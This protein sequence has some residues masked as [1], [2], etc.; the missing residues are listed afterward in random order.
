MAILGL[1]L[2]TCGGGPPPPVEPML[3]EDLC[4]FC[5]MTI[6]DRRLAAEIV[7]RG[8]VDYF[9][10]IGCMLDWIDLH[11]LAPGSMAYVF[12]FRAGEPL[13]AASAFYVRSTLVPTPMGHGLVA[14]AGEAEAS[15]A[16]AELGGTVASWAQLQADHLG[17]S[18]QPEPSDQGE[19]REPD[20]Q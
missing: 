2:L 14:F 13:P 5:R 9:D 18:R 12:D 17:P 19:R 16:A 3:D 6:S 15:A 10:D 11:G 4:S 7:R 1:I 8:G 20:A